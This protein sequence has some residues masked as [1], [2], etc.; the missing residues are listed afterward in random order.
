MKILVIGG[1]AGGASA[2]ARAARLDSNAEIIVFERGKYISFA[3]CGLPYH[4]GGVIPQ[5]E[6]LLVMTSEKFVGRTG[7][8]VRIQS[9]VTAINPKAREVEVK[10][11]KTGEAYKESYDKLIMSTGSSPVVPPIPGADDP[12]VITLWNIPDMDRIKGRVDAG[13]KSAVVVGGGFIGM[14]VAENLIERGVETHLVELQPQVLPPIDKE[15]ASMLSDTMAKHGVK[16]H[17]NTKAT[18]IVRNPEG[19]TVKL[20]DGESVSAGLVVMAVGVRPN[21]ELAK[22]AGLETGERGGVKVNDRLQT[23]DPDIY[24]VGDVIE[25]NDFVLNHPA[26]IP[27]AGPA[28]R[29]ARIA[30]NNIFGADETYKG[31]LGTSIVKV[32]ELAAASVGASE[33]RLK[34][35]GRDYLKTYILPASH[36]SYYPGA[37]PLYIKLLF[38]KSGKILGAQIVGRDGVD[39]RIDVLATAMRNNLTVMD[40]EELELAYAPPFGSAK[41][42]VNFAGFVAHNIIKGDTIVVDPD[43]IPSDAFLLD[44]RQPEEVICGAIPDAV[45]IPLGKLRDN[46]DRLPK[47]REIIPFCKLGLRGYVAERLLRDKGFKVRN[48]SGGYLVWKL[49]HPTGGEVSPSCPNPAPAS[50]G[51]IGETDAAVELNACGLQCPGPIVQVKNKI[52]ELQDGQ[53]LK[54]T[55]SDAGFANDLPAWCNATGNQLMKIVEADGKI[56]AVV[57][58]GQGGAE[59]VPAGTAEAKPKR[60]TLVLFSNDLDKAMAAFIIA[61]GFAALGHKVTIFCTFWG[62]NVLR[63]DHPPAVKKDLLSRMF[64][65]MMPRGAK[66]LALSKMNMMGMGTAMMKHVMNKQNVDSLPDLINQARSLGVELVACEMAMNVM[67]IKQE[68]LLDGVSTAGVGNFAGMAAESGT[69]LFI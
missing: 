28:N 40:L 6:S 53:L 31:S 57:R 41:D 59:P 2:A 61:T 55:A 9:E 14:E 58:K 4:I 29:Q 69:T 1:V 66:K 50:G 48:M 10:N 27:L 33:K 39:K 47:D 32:F 3:N 13:I 18:E 37:D 51:S 38:E 64:G 49:F 26:M 7:A 54:V 25:V 44:V 8:E 43:K 19:L 11:L 68:E 62:L 23:S 60:A 35:M 20:E 34:Q 45:N 56:E 30:V 22:A 63:K 67:G 16:L 5:R 21:S 46:L 52:D 36:A 17:L 42:P 12:D 15:M 24:A 65:W